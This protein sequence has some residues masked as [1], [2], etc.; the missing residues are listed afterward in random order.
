MT[1]ILGI[2][3]GSV[4]TGIG[5][6]DSRSGQVVHVHHQAIKTGS[7]SFPERLKVIFEE[8]SGIIHT[9]Q[10][11]TVAVESV[12]VSKNADS[13]LKLGQARGAAICAAVAMNRDVA[14]YTPRHVKQAIVGRG[15]AEKQ[16]IQHM[17]GLL[18][19]IKDAIQSD[20]ADAL[21]VAVCHAHHLQTGE[22]MARNARGWA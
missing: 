9:H 8:I 6:V 22:K 11:D 12:F 19:S 5:I 21:G 4:I 18:L 2:D 15:S 1:R 3:P 14:E 7:G 16:Q 17:I 20:A 10:P 13:A